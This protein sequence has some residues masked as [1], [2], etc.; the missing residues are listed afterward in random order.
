MVDANILISASLF[1][2]SL[3]GS[4]FAHILK[5]HEL[6]LCN[7]TLEEIKNVFQ[8]KFPDRNK[9]LNRLIK[10]LKY[11]HIKYEIYNFEK[12]PQIRD[13][14]DTPLL[15]YAIESKVNI[16][17]TGDKDFDEINI[18]NLKIINPRKYIEEYMNKSI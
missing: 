13:I 17:L 15:V 12:Y 2:N 4:V 11:E 16:L 8:K 3:V 9:H 7:Y 5:N 14:K 10:N 1:P 18:E 6:V